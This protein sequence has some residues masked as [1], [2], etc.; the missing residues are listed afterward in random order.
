VVTLSCS[1]KATAVARKGKKVVARGK[2]T[3]KVVLKVPRRVRG[4]LTVVVT[5]DATK[6]TRTVKLR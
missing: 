1:C 3:G 4:K 2:G 5:V 6:L